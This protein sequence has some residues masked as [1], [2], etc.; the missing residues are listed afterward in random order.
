M[1]LRHTQLRFC[2]TVSRFEEQNLDVTYV[3]KTRFWIDN[4]VE[5]IETSNSSTKEHFY[6][7]PAEPWDYIKQGLRLLVPAHMKRFLKPDFEKKTY[8]CE[9]KVVNKKVYAIQPVPDV[10][11]WGQS[12]F[13]QYKSTS[14]W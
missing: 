14:P 7:V 10:I 3:I 2:H 9:N 8:V 12:H 5:V 13:T 4:T 11:P 1:P 6:L